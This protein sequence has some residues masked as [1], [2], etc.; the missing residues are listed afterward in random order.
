MVAAD[1]LKLIDMVDYLQNHFLN[2]KT[3]W[4]EQNL[5]KV[6]QTSLMRPNFMEL[7]AYCKTLMNENPALLFHS[8]AFPTLQKTILLDL[9][10]RDDL[11]LAEVTIWRNLIK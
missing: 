4:I 6:Y 11:S 2:N 3:P 9:I 7:Q 10:K 8:E 5:I 1:D